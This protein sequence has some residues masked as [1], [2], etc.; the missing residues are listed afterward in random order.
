MLSPD[1]NNLSKALEFEFSSLN[2]K[3]FSII[4]VQEYIE[5][6]NKT[7]II[8]LLK[9]SICNKV[10]INLKPP[11]CKS[12]F[13]IVFNITTHY[14]IYKIY[15]CNKKMKIFNITVSE[16]N[17]SIRIDRFITESIGGEFSRNRIQN[18]IKDNF[19]KKNGVVFNDISYKIQKGDNLEIILDNAKESELKEKNIDLDIVYE[20]NDLIV[21]N[22]QAGLT[23]HPGCGN[24]ENTLVNALMYHKKGEL[25]TIGGVIRPGIVHRLDKDTSGL[26]VIA[27]NDFS[28]KSLTEQIQT[29]KLKRV[30]FAFV[31]GRVIPS[32]GKIEGFIERSKLNRLKM[33][34]T[35]NSSSRYSLTHY[36]TIKNFSDVAT[37][38]ECRLDTG[39]THQIRAHFSNKKFP[40]I[41][42]Q[43]YGGNARRVRGDKTTYSDFVETFSRQAL[44]SKK[45]SFLQPTSNIELNFE[46]DLPDDMLELEKNLELL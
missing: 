16:S 46:V 5:K 3:N 10:I 38:A 28:H 41:G 39:R 6:H 2:L 30:Y 21:I 42:D 18:I 44:H 20:D 19:L 37:L 27:K 1:Q 24:I 12:I 26:M 11:A 40:L 45:I 13:S 25:S 4:N 29:R 22:K 14:S 31:W 32:A 43:L 35:N 23:T 17:T 34:M 9:K 33:I 7:T 36:K 8:T 15:I